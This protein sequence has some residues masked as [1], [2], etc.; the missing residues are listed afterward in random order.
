MGVLLDL[1]PEVL[2]FITPF[3]GLIGCDLLLLTGSS[4]LRSKLNNGGFASISFNDTLPNGW[5]LLVSK[6]DLNHFPSSS[7]L[8]ISSAHKNM[9]TDIHMDTRRYSSEWTLTL[10]Q[11]RYINLNSLLLNCVVSLE[12]FCQSIMTSKIVLRESIPRLR[13]L[14]LKSAILP[15]QPRS[16]TPFQY[17]IGTLP[18]VLTE[19]SLY[20]GRSRYQ[21]NADALACEWPETIKHLDFCFQWAYSSVAWSKM[22][23]ELQTVSQELGGDRLKINTVV[24]HAKPWRFTFPASLETMFVSPTPTLFDDYTLSNDMVLDLP[25]RLTSFTYDADYFDATEPVH[26]SSFPPTLTFMSI[27]GLRVTWQDDTLVHLKELRLQ[28]FPTSY[29]FKECQKFVLLL[30]DEFSP[31]RIQDLVNK[32]SPKRTEISLSSL[33]S[34][35]LS[36]TLNPNKNELVCDWLLKPSVWEGL[37]VLHIANL[38]NQNNRL[39]LPPNITELDA[40]KIPNVDAAFLDAIP[41][42]LISLSIS[43]IRFVDP[44]AFLEFLSPSCSSEP[45]VP[46]ITKAPLKLTNLS[47]RSEPH[48]LQKGSQYEFQNPKGLQDDDWL[49]SMV[50]ALPST[51]TSLTLDFQRHRTWD[52]KGKNK[53]FPLGLCWPPQLQYLDLPYSFLSVASLLQ[54]DFRKIEYIRPAYISVGSLEELLKIPLLFS[55]S[56]LCSLTCLDHIPIWVPHFVCQEILAFDESDEKSPKPSPFSVTFDSSS[57]FEAAMSSPQLSSIRKLMRR[58]R[59]VGTIDLDSWAVEGRFAGFSIDTSQRIPEQD[60]LASAAGRPKKSLKPSSIFDDDDDDDDDD[61]GDLFADAKK[62]PKEDIFAPAAPPTAASSS[63]S[64]TSLFTED[65]FAAPS[66][67]ESAKKNKPIV[68]D[69]Y[70]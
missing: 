63:T 27:K 62:K 69:F 70:K 31:F 37:K 24:Q 23:Q 56:P 2:S 21:L 7:T 29:G 26:S 38:I 34:L 35:D 59:F 61:D 19:M 46:G 44:V 57:L 12:S 11:D 28:H 47:L 10:L 15:D 41:S 17:L 32:L 22:I 1:P 66:V 45:L 67:T 52:R 9:I 6:V 49:E 30:S 53:S 8:A 14:T 65:I 68:Q 18:S 4:I 55:S 51:L 39:V 50:R 33:T 42:C 16:E 54:F 20:A 36:G 5:R 58:L 13:S 48:F 60:L 43:G 25:R 64:S 3:L 40:K